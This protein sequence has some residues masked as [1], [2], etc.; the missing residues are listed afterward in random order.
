MEI[1]VYAFHPVTH[2]YG[3]PVVL[4][5][6]RGDMDPLEPGRWLVP[7]NCLEAV[8][9][10]PGEGQYV[11]AVGGAWVLR[12]IATQPAPGQ[13]STPGGTAPSADPATALRDGIQ[14][15]MDNQARALGYDDIGTAVTYADEPSVPKFQIEGAVFRAW[16]SLVWAACYAHL[17]LV[18]AGEAA[19]PT[20]AEAIAMLPPLEMP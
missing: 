7:G 14:A 17:S 12:N 16:R 6:E 19:M 13:P 3:A 15:Y 9:P 5:D 1:T 8:P 11:A 20:L 2:A 10:T 4:S 18:Q